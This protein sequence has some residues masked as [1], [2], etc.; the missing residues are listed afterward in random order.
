MGGG[1]GA[2]G[3]AALAC[4]RFLERAP[5]FEAAEIRGA[6]ALGILLALFLLFRWLRM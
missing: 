5:R 3:R 2:A 6:I 1:E 4:R